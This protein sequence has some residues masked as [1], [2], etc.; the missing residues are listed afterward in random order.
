MEKGRGHHVGFSQHGGLRIDTDIEDVKELEEDEV[1]HRLIQLEEQSKIEHETCCD[2]LDSF[3][4]RERLVAIAFWMTLIVFGI[5]VAGR[6][7]VVE[8]KHMQDRIA[9]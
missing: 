3:L 1:R 6:V 8:G 9:N 7:I 5:L 2:K 4:T